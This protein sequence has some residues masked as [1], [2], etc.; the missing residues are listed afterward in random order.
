MCIRAAT[1]Q[2]V[3]FQ[4]YNLK[5]IALNS[6]KEKQGQ[7]KKKTTSYQTTNASGMPDS[8]LQKRERKT[9]GSGSGSYTVT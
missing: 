2:R 5:T 9:D 3:A 4:I 8:L 1:G 7:L 6:S